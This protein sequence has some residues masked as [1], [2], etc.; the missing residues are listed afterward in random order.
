[1]EFSIPPRTLVPV[2]VT[3]HIYNIG[4]SPRAHAVNA[5]LRTLGTGAFHCG[6]EVYGCE[7]SYSDTEDGLGD[8]VFASRPRCCDSH[9]YSE[10]VP[11]GMTSMKEE[12]VLQLINLLKGYWPV[13]SYDTLS[14][15]CCHFCDELCQRLRVGPIPKWVMSLAGAGAAIAAT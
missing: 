9:T 10:S 6:V 12:D 3:L 8:G 5:F 2:P 7:W 15:N 14:H 11:M 13:A 4:T 1:M